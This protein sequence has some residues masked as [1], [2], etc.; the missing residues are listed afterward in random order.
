MSGCRPDIGAWFAAQVIA[1]KLGYGSSGDP[2]E[3]NVFEKQL[4]W[5]RGGTELPGRGH[6]V[7]DSGHQQR[8]Q[9]AESPGPSRSR[10]P[11]RSRV[12]GFEL[13][14]L[15]VGNGSASEL[16]GNNASYTATVTPEAS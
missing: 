7:P 14:D 4:E 11:S 8:R 9:C 2:A 13:A 15:V 6:H 1:V 12:T 10:S 16:Q 5:R 3:L